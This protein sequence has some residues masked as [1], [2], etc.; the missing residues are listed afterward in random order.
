LGSRDGD[1]SISDYI[2][3]VNPTLD[4]RLRSA[5][6]D[7]IKAIAAIPEPFAL[8]ATYPAA[9]NA[10]KVVGTDLV[11]VLEEVYSQLSK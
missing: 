5:I 4:N 1:P 11:D 7:A 9:D 8:H 10:V 2:K 6:E 3:S